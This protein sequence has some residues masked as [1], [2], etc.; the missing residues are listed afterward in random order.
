MRK[1]GERRKQGNEGKRRGRVN[2][3]M[4]IR[5]LLGIVH[6]NVPPGAGS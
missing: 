5:G 2:N 4:A 1:G 6:V 3:G